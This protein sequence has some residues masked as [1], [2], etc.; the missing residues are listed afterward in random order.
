MH[1]NWNSNVSI[2]AITL[3][4]KPIMLNPWLPRRPGSLL[5]GLHRNFPSLFVCNLSLSATI[6]YKTRSYVLNSFCSDEKYLFQCHKSRNSTSWICHT[7][8]T[9][10][11]QKSPW[12]SSEM[13]E[14][15]NQGVIHYLTRAQEMGRSELTLYRQYE[16]LPPNQPVQHTHVEFSQNKVQCKSFN[17]TSQCCKGSHKLITTTSE[18]CTHWCPNQQTS[19]YQFMSGKAINL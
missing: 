2:E 12:V 11:M 3:C 1:S 13:W 18:E 10:F 19:K 14:M 9:M 16:L 17:F 8:L 15:N 7:Q 5:G 6:S 4:M